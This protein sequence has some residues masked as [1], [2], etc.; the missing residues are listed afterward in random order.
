MITLCSQS[1]LKEAQNAMKKLEQ[2]YP[3]LFEKLL[4]V[5]NLTRAMQLTYQYM[6][7]LIMNE[8]PGNSHP[9]FIYRSVLRL[10]KKEIHKLTDDKD[11]EALRNTFNEF[12]HT[13]YARLSQLALGKTPESLAGSTAIIH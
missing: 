5:I 12:Q 2:S 13:G 11:I 4:D 3:E 6:G 7:S 10:Y 8:D 9:Q 1:E